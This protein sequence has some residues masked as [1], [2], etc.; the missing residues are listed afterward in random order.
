GLALREARTGQREMTPDL[1]VAAI[2][3]ISFN[4]DQ[5]EAHASGNAHLRHD[6]RVSLMHARRDAAVELVLTYNQVVESAPAGRPDHGFLMPQISVP[7]GP[8]SAQTQV[9]FSYPSLDGQPHT[10]S[11]HLG[12][13]VTHRANYEEFATAVRGSYAGYNPV[14]PAILNQ[15]RH[16]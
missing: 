14:R 12:E 15:P 4:S 13:I 6:A 3:T 1:I 11:I 5:L 10:A 7:E 8:M 16:A 9:T 2:T